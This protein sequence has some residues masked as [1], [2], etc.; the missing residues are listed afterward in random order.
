M[1][2]AKSVCFQTFFLR[3]DHVIGPSLAVNLI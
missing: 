2:G 1:L 3:Q